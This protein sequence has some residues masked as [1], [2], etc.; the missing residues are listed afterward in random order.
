MGLNIRMATEHDAADWQQLLKQVLGSDKVAENVYDLSRLGEQLVGPQIDQ[1]WLAEVNGK[2]RGSISLLASNSTIADPVANLG[3]YIVVPESYQ[4]GSAEALL[5]GMNEVCLQRRQT[6]VMRVPASDNAQQRLLEK[7]G[8]VCA[9]FQPMKHLCMVREGILFYICPGEPVW[10]TR[11]PIS[12]SLPQILLLASEVL[13]NLQAP[14]PESAR[15]GLTGYPLQTDLALEDATPEAYDS[16]KALAQPSNPPV[17][18]S[19]R[20]NR[21]LGVLRVGSDPSVKTLLGRRDGNVVAGMAYY[22][23]DH[24]KFVRVV[25]AF[26]IDELSTGDLLRR[27]TE[28]ARDEFNAVYV[29]ADFLVTAPRALKSAEQLGFVPVAFL[30]GFFN[31]GSYCVDLAKMIKLNAQVAVD[32]ARLTPQA[33]AMVA[34]VDRGF[35][36][37]KVGLAVINLLR[38]LPIFNGLGDGELGKLARLFTQKLYRPQ[39]VVFNK[40]E[41]SG[42]AFIVMRGQ[43]DVRLEDGAPPVASLGLGSILGE[44]AFLDGSPRNASASAAQPSILLVV[45]RP[46]LNALL[47]LEPRLGMVILRNIA[48]DV[49]NKLRA[50]NAALIFSRT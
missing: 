20:F 48:V 10:L 49:S 42:E 44:Q 41:S 45:Q 12:R 47:Q 36:D 26:A 50:S 18:I 33:A 39:E 9:G 24:D 15:D 4:E 22:F 2:L 40:G 34:A 28:L 6:A 17:E 37:Q 27:V 1:T 38:G 16:C 29:E 13:K 14:A 23:D 5:R 25:D 3:R 19:G 7:L 21:G 43:I 32:D 30:P 11:G 8:F 46:A 35:Q 31:S